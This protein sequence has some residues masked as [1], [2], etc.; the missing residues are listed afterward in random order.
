MRGSFTQLFTNPHLF[1]CSILMLVSS[2]VFGAVTTFIPLYA[3]QINHGSAAVYLMLQ[4]AMIVAARFFLRKK[5][6]SDGRWHPVFV[7][8]IILALTVA[9]LCTGF[10]IVGGFAVFYSGALLMGLAQAMLYP[11]LTTYLTFVLP[12]NNRNVLIGLFI[13]MADLGVS[14]S[15]V[16]MG[17]IADLLSYTCVYLICSLLGGSLLFFIYNQQGEK[18]RSSG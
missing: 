3:A 9:S 18:F 16:I 12:E 6:P 13:A 8:W 10:S 15:G 14:L 5:I 4:A 1:R 11:T 2:I 7:T 17:P